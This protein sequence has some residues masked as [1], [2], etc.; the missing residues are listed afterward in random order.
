MINRNV[1]IYM[2]LWKYIKICVNQ[3]SIP[4]PSFITSHYLLYFQV[5]PDFGS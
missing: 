2:D 4:I 3:A 5:F 1:S